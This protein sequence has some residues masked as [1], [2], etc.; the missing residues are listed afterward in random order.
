MKTEFDVSYSA[1]SQ[2]WQI[3]AFQN[4]LNFLWSALPLKFKEVKPD[5]VA[6]PLAD[7]TTLEVQNLMDQLWKAGVRPT[8][9]SESDTN[10][11]KLHLEDM[12]TIVSNSL[13]IDL[14]GGE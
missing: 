9:E 10:N 3:Y 11:M 2:R 13:G 6:P 7:L 1:A 4:G 14:R 12:R 5:V 8:G